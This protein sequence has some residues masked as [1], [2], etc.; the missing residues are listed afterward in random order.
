[1]SSTEDPIQLPI[2]AIQIPNVPPKIQGTDTFLHIASVAF[3]MLVLPSFVLILPIIY[4]ASLYLYPIQVLSVFLAYFFYV[5]FMDPDAELKGGWG[6]VGV[7]KWFNGLG[8]WDLFREYFM[9]R[10]I[11]TAELRSDRNYIF[12]AHPHGVYCLGVWANLTSNARNLNAVLP[13]IKIRPCTLPINFK[14]P[15][16]REFILSMGAI[17]VDRK[18]L[19]TLLKSKTGSKNSNGNALLLVTGGG[20]EYLHMEPG[21]MDLVILK[22]KGFVKLSLTTGAPLVPVITFGENDIFTRLDTPFVRKMTKFTQNLAHFA[23]PAFTGRW[24]TFIPRRKPLITVVGAPLEVEKVEKP[25]QEQ[26]DELHGKYL[27][28]LTALYDEYKD[29]YFKDRVRDMKFVK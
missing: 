2:G 13:G 29:I 11:K 10:L 3:W 23:F 24:G 18:A 27:A 12:C 20:E 6:I 5:F 26:I 1:M 9:A 19:H 7:G 16:W 25:S 4:I 15:F 22:R 28:H 21:T 17:S 8:L 14:I